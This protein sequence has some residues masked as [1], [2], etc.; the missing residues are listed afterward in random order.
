M[1]KTRTIFVIK[2]GA[3]PR[4]WFLT[5][6]PSTE[7]S[8]TVESDVAMFSSFIIHHHISQCWNFAGRSRV[9]R[10]EDCP[11]SQ[12]VLYVAKAGKVCD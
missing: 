4:R 3:A 6:I 11:E 9:F 2:A 7:F 10:H 8:T 1:T 12:H 5:R